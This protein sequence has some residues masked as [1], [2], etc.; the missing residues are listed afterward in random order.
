[1][2]RIARTFKKNDGC[3][4]DCDGGDYIGGTFAEEETDNNVGFWEKRKERKRIGIK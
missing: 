2:T 4:R 1:M 3:C